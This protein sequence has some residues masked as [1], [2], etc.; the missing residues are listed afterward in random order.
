M[1]MSRPVAAPLEIRLFGSFEVSV[2]GQ[3]LRRLRTRKGEWLVALLALRRGEELERGWL[4][5]TLWPESRGEQALLSLRKTLQDLRQA[6]GAEALRLHSPTRPTLCLDLTGAAVDA[7]AFDAAIARG[8]ASAL[9]EAAGLY[10]G[11]LLAECAEEWVF[12]ER[13]AREEDYLS[14]LETLAAHAVSRQDHGAAEPYLRRAAA[15]N[16]LRESPQRALMQ[17]LAESGNYAAAVAVYRELREY[18]HRE[19]NAEPAGETKAL[20]EAIRAEARRA[21]EGGRERGREGVTE[22]DR[23]SSLP[24]SLAPFLPR[25]QVGEDT[26]TFLFTDVEGSTRLWEEHPEA[27]REALARHQEILD[28][29]IAAHGG[30]VFKTVGDAALASFATASEAVDAAIA[31]QQAL[32]REEWGAVGA[33][34]VRMAVHTGTVAERDGDYSGPA[35][36]RAARVLS[37]GHGGQILITL[38]TEQLLRDGLPEA[39]Q[40]RD[41][42]VHRLRDLQQAEHL[43]QVLH[44]DLP[45]D[46]PPLRS[47]E[48]FAH[49]LPRQLTSFVGREGEV[50]EVKRLLVGP[51]DSPSD[52]RQEAVISPSRTPLLT[53]TGAGGCGKTRLALEVA[54]GLLPEY[55]D[56]IWWVE[57]APLSDPAL[58]PQA[59]ATALGLRE[60]PGRPLLATLTHR[61]RAKSALLLLDNCEHLL[62]ASAHLSES[63][64]RGCP[65]LQILATSRE[66]LGVPGERTYRVPSLSV[67]DLEVGS[68]VEG[69]GSRVD[70]AAARSAAFDPRPSTLLQYEAVRLFV[71]RAAL[72]QPDFVLTEQ[73]AP[74]VAHICRQLDGIPLAIELAAARV[75][76]LPVEKLNERLSDMFRLLTG[77]SRTALP[78]QQT[79]QATIDWSYNLL[80][81]PERTL[82]RRLSA[83]AGG[84]TLEAAEAVC[85]DEEGRRQKAVGSRD[86]PSGLPSAF[87]LLPSD[88]LD[89]LTALVEKSLV[90]YDAWHGD[91]RYRLPE[92][93]RQY[94][95]DRLLQAGEVEAVRARHRE[96]FLALAERAEP[97]L[98]GPDQSAW[99]ERVETE[100]DN[101]RATLE[102]CRGRS[103]ATEAGLRLAAALA[104]FW[105]V[106]GYREEGRERLAAALAAEGADASL[107]RARRAR[108]LSGAGRL[109][110]IQGDYAA[111]RPLLEESLAL[112]REL[113]DRMGIARSLG[114][115]ANA[116]AG[117][118]DHAT[119]RALW[120][121][122]LA[123]YREFGDRAGQAGIL[124][125]LG[126]STLVSGRPETA[127]ALLAES[128]SLF[129]ETGDR[130]S[131]ATALRH[132]GRIAA[133]VGELVQARTRFEQAL[134]ISR[135]LGDRAGQAL[136]LLN[137]GGIAVQQGA[138]SR[139]RADY[140]ESLAIHRE[141]EISGGVGR[142]LALQGE[143][144]E[145]EGD[146]R[147]AESRYRESLAVARQLGERS[148]AVLRLVG[149][150]RVAVAQGELASAQS[151]LMESETLD[152]QPIHK[153]A[154]AERLHA[155]GRL[156]RARGE[157][158]A[159]R[160]RYA[161]SLA[162]LQEQGVRVRV[163]ALLEAIASLWG[164]QGGGTQAARL[165]GAADALRTTMG[166]PVPASCRAAYE[167]DVAAARA[168]MGEVAF[169]AAWAAGQALPW[170]QAVDEA[171]R[172]AQMD[173]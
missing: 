76:V 107:Y 168:G 125:N 10:R 56:G 137:L 71:E 8:D 97:E 36:N 131:A 12:P 89:L 11:P 147:T 171:L 45:A 134:A 81:E 35:L 149:L 94:S 80:S 69:R 126:V 68:R 166:T 51:G 98:R 38:A 42:G 117:Q 20:F 173:G 169:A 116:A 158:A 152:R 105:E 46:F 114:A 84:W 82:L 75:K 156:A 88:I 119:A 128:L 33:L 34:R 63:L 92:T 121:E 115:L 120:Q 96:F 23:L 153:L 52:P 124:N 28:A 163:P 26:L 110:E 61:L 17:V 30:R 29:V 155:W 122:A 154:V 39:V 24:R 132:L 111:A 44:P 3:P 118:Q 123:L 67:P 32:Q 104:M 53:L 100:H 87:C 25:S 48:A 50:A 72:S 9:E 95:R 161:E 165:L 58:V 41:L 108:A 79:L 142:L 77:G 27:A 47:L 83:F 103:E 144:A 102:W 140:D 129:Q 19:V 60:E 62:D 148:T 86:C 55:P 70:P 15:V 31:G 5:G 14:A 162:M 135:E 127:S 73:K 21:A 157:A 40:L 66:G 159:A 57:F 49:N 7:L 170:E 6:L 59:V 78:R 74:I 65:S 151:L 4:A 130:R 93:V 139:A 167:A 101:F 22:R 143:L 172:E 150:A 18:L 109:A 90:V 2:H 91:G 113:G 133:L 1:G 164:E 160:A 37:T 146:D 138:Y 16:P 43:F 145:A 112:Q 64:L 13:Q 54:A 106:R 85:G 136:N 141:L 99:L